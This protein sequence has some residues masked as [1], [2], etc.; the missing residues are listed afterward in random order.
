[1]QRLR[2]VLTFFLRFLVIIGPLIFVGSWVILLTTHHRYSDDSLTLSIAYQL[3]FPGLV[4]SF[5]APIF[6]KMAKKI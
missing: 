1:M 2:T 3:W 6:W 5:F 4:L